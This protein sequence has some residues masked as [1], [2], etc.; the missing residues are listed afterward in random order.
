MLLEQFV[1]LHYQRLEEFSSMISLYHHLILST[2][3]DSTGLEFDQGV[4]YIFDESKS[5][6]IVLVD[7]WNMVGILNNDIHEE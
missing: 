5:I 4:Q 7:P 1:E 2:Q 6:S 3:S